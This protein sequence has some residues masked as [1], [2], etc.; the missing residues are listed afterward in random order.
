[1]RGKFFGSEDCG[2]GCATEALDM[3]NDP[4]ADVDQEVHC[5]SN[6]IFAWRLIFSLLHYEIPTGVTGNGVFVVTMI[7]LYVHMSI[8][9]RT[10]AV[11]HRSDN[12][13]RMPLTPTNSKQA[14]LTYR[15]SFLSSALDL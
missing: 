10:Y 6:C 13:Y 8:S 3:G 2:N 11:V 15:F 7:R 5:S 12:P 14:Y 4:S 9:S 1:M